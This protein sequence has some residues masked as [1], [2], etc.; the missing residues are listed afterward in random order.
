VKIKSKLLLALLSVAIVPICVGCIFSY[1]NSR[2]FLTNSIVNHLK[3][4]SSLQHARVNA[5]IARNL[6]RLS[7]VSS[8]TQLRMSLARVQ[9]GGTLQD[10]QKLNRILT[11]A[12][13]SVNDFLE[14][15]VYSPA[16]V[17]VASTD[18]ARVGK[19]HF[20]PRFL[21]RCRR[22]K[23]VDYFFLDQ[24]GMQ[25]LYLS[26][27]LFL[28]K[29]LV[30][31]I[32]I[33][34]RVNSILALVQDYSGLGRTGETLIVRRNGSGDP[35]FLLPTRFGKDDAVGQT[36]S[37]Q[38]N[39]AANFAFA[40]E[41]VLVD[42]IDY[43]EQPVLAIGR[44]VEATDWGLVVKI[45]KSEAYA[46]VKSLWQMSVLILLL[47]IVGVL[48]VA[49]YIS[50]GISAPIDQLAVVAGRIAAGDLTGKAEVNSRDEVGA[51]ARSFNTMVDSLRQTTVD[52]E[53]K[54][55][56]LRGEVSAHEQS[57]R[58]KEQLIE[59]LQTAFNEIK[60]L[61]GIVPI[62]SSCKKIRDD[63][64]FWSQIESYVR[65]HSEAE[66]SHG[67]CPDCAKTLYPD[68]KFTEEEKK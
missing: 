60:T 66:F 64:G 14:I 47:A 58:E 23:T 40:G 68:V 49:L 39:Y 6:E 61:K 30:G 27:P 26:G 29:K 13:A 34:S 62:C 48:L 7:L 1:Y 42:C 52:L 37:R 32:V 67:L 55:E 8:R 59:E 20:D 12:L 65:D 56:E 21:D 15:T 2:S 44:H 63:Q 46:P 53:K 54:V 41:K 51:L 3:S 57:E 4:V 9:D 18:P 28:D 33:E 43:R 22:E 25:G 19:E 16:G 36:L 45:D 10:Q 50:T 17:V 24:N 11:D 31:V 5:I 35:V 38:R